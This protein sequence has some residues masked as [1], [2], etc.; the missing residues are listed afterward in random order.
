M[1]DCV[2]TRHICRYE[3]PYDESDN[4]VWLLVAAKLTVIRSCS[5]PKHGC[6]C[7]VA[8]DCQFE[9][10]SRA[11]LR[12]LANGRCGVNPVPL[13]ERG[14]WVPGPAPWMERLVF[15]RAAR[16]LYI[17]DWLAGFLFC[18]FHVERMTPCGSRVVPCGAGLSPLSSTQVK[19]MGEGA[20]ELGAA[21]GACKGSGLVV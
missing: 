20:R 13:P 19:G 1:L 12:V 7:R 9:R 2:M 21:E 15:T 5:A 16:W 6:G 3:E 11:Q 8:G 17:A 14:L 10:A 18:L 4:R